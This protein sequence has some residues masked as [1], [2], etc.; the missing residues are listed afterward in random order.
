MAEQRGLSLSGY[1][2]LPFSREYL[3]LHFDGDAA[4][5][6]REYLDVEA[7]RLLKGL[8]HEN[9]D[10]CNLIFSQPRE[11]IVASIW[12]SADAGGLRQFPF[13]FFTSIPAQ[14][15]SPSLSGLWT[16]LKTVF[17]DLREAFAQAKALPDRA[18][19]DR[20]FNPEERGLP[21]PSAPDICHDRQQREACSTG[22]REWAE[23][24]FGDV[25]EYFPVALWHLM[26]MKAAL[27]TDT[28][29]YAGIKLPLSD[30]VEIASQVDA[31]LQLLYDGVPTLQ[32]DPNIVVSSLAGGKGKLLAI[33]FRPF[34]VGDLAVLEAGFSTPGFVD[35]TVFQ[36]PSSLAGF[37]EFNEGLLK[38]LAAGLK[39]DRITDIVKDMNS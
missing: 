15:T 37:G 9:C 21:A 22:I 5:A 33:F 13:S 4:F 23:G 28:E 26:G 10:E 1:G 27:Q 18:A 24:A 25:S 29:A 16:G 36:E 30:S 38:Q 39:L 32:W 20:V 3:R 11:R 8:D 12:P 17:E 34:R 6:F 19:M 7:G 35:L 14:E 31:W 2:K